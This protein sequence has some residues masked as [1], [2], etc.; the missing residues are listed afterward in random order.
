MSEQT[1]PV[2]ILKIL[3]PIPDI[4]VPTLPA[5]HI[6]YAEDGTA[7]L[8][9]AGPSKV[10]RADVAPELDRGAYQ[11]ALSKREKAAV[12]VDVVIPS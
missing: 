3:R 10:R 9:E 4:S 7:Q 8:G 5:R 12:S 6:S 11:R 2:P 1:G